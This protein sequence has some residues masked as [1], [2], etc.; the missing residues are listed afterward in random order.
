MKSTDGRLGIDRQP[1]LRINKA[2]QEI[3]GMGADY[4]LTTNEDELCEYLVRKYQNQLPVSGNAKNEF[5]QEYLLLRDTI[6]QKVVKRK[7]NF[8]Q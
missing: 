4:L 7:A 8:F 3:Q 1:N 2:I 5:Q 6:R